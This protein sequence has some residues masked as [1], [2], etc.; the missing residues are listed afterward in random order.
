MPNQSTNTETDTIQFLA[1]TSLRKNGF[2][3]CSDLVGEELNPI[4]V[5]LILRRDNKS[6]LFHYDGSTVTF[7][8]KSNEELSGKGI[9]EVALFKSKQYKS[10]LQSV[11]YALGRFLDNVEN[12]KIKILYDYPYEFDNHSYTQLL[13]EKE[14][15][16]N[17]ID[18]SQITLT[19]S[20]LVVY[21]INSIGRILT[22]DFMCISPGSWPRY[23]NEA[24]HPVPENME[25]IRVRPKECLHISIPE[26]LAFFPLDY[27]FCITKN[28][29]FRQI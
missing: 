18:I 20:T 17:Y 28:F 1:T 10:L 14:T 22:N 7:E 19:C 15:E 23:R 21:S 3:I 24:I 2:Y 9:L 6:M 27:S 26:E 25:N 8:E 16:D 5:G 29:V 11:E 4:H 13:I 12:K